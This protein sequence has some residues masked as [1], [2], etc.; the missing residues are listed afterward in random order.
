MPPSSQDIVKLITD[1]GW[2]F[3]EQK[4]SHMHYKHP[5]KT[6]R[7]TIPKGRKD[8]PIGTLKSILKQ[9]GLD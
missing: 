8:L 1:D 4:G 6:G 3:V 9:A 7:V 5:T 2:Y